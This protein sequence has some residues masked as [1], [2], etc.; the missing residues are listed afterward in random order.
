MKFKTLNLFPLF[1]LII[2]SSC[3][4]KQLPVN[5]DLEVR[6][7]YM[8]TSDGSIKFAKTDPYI[9]TIRTALDQSINLDPTVQYQSMDGF[10]FSLTGGSAQHLIKMSPDK[11]KEVLL[12]LFSADGNGIGVSY[13]RISIGSS[14]LDE[15]AF[16]YDDVAPGTEDLELDQFTLQEDENDLIPILQEILDINPEIK[17]MASP[18]S[19]PAWMKTN[20]STK[21]GS[22]EKKYFN[23]YAEYMVKYIQS[24]SGHGIVIDAITVQN[25]P[26]H[27]GNN[28]SLYMSA[29]DQAEFIKNSLGPLFNKEN[30]KAKIIIY[31]HNA[32]RIDYPM[33]VLSDSVAKS[34]VDGTAFHL[35]GGEIEY[36][37]VV[38]EAHPD[39]N[40]YFTEQWVGAPGNFEQDFSWHIKNLIIGASR[41]WCKTVLEWNLTSNPELKPHTPGGCTKCLGAITIDGDDVTKN[42]AY[43]TIA[44][45]SKFVRPGSKRIYSSYND[46]LS[47]VAFLTPDNS[48]I[49]IVLNDSD[50]KQTFKVV[51][52][53][54]VVALSQ[55]ASSA[56]TYVL[57]YN[58]LNQ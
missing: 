11:R 9:D 35:Y 55:E 5:N 30:I 10:G 27:P 31:D 52:D 7:A 58:L 23:V 25:E 33:T 3:I 51:I 14:D 54:N 6:V 43:Y 50:S 8:T 4:N 26:L 39:R 42:P 47:N 49:L 29:E 28:P 15:K 53:D 40:I 1:A 18:W 22:L 44:H 20:S 36:L 45:A 48:I 24:M 57:N 38:H 21:G 34:Y 41:N 37:S 2:L 32:D 19:P 46:T 17:I 12:D 56:V 13:L 16:S